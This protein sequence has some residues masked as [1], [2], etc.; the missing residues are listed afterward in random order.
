MRTEG[1]ILRLEVDGKVYEFECTDVELRKALHAVDERL[2]RQAEERA[3]TAEGAVS[4]E[5]PDFRPLRR[6]MEDAARVVGTVFLI[7][8]GAVLVALPA[9]ATDD[10]RCLFVR[11]FECRFWWLP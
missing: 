2:A 6:W 5:D 10:M 4:D 7:L 9:I 11:T 3:E 8:L 1:G